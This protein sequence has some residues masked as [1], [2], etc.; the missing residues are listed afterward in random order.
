MAFSTWP[1]GVWKVKALIQAFRGRNL[2][3]SGFCRIRPLQK[4]APMYRQSPI[5]ISPAPSAPSAGVLPH[6]EPFQLP[7]ARQENSYTTDYTVYWR[8]KALKKPPVHRATVVAFGRS[9]PPRKTR[10][11]RTH[12]KIPFVPVD[13][14]SQT[15]Q[16]YEDLCEILASSPKQK[17][18]DFSLT[19]QDSAR[20]PSQIGIPP[21]AAT[22]MATR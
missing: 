11:Q 9:S 16:R 12:Q 22:S 18:L 14:S 21:L 3:K 4:T 17:Q 2:R 15:L 19:L 7:A 8:I 6:P 13:G 1:R 5:P 10:S 20:G